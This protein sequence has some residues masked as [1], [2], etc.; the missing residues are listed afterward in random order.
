MN[1]TTLAWKEIGASTHVA[2]RGQDGEYMVRP[3]DYNI[4]FEARWRPRNG[5]TDM[6]GVR[7]SAAEAKSLC[8]AHYYST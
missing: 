7:T 8:E 2:M 3:E 6:L 4:G 5:W 1:K